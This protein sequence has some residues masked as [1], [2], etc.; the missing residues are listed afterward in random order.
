MSL[1]A[2]LNSLGCGIPVISDGLSDAAAT[3][4]F[5]MSSGNLSAYIDRMAYLNANLVSADGNSIVL[6]NSTNSG[7]SVRSSSLVM[8]AKSPLVGASHFHIGGSTNMD[9]YLNLPSSPLSFSSN[10]LSPSVIHAS[11]KEQPTSSLRGQSSQLGEKKSCPQL[12]M[13]GTATSQ[14]TSQAQRGSH[15][16]GKRKEPGIVQ[17]SK[18]PRLDRNQENI[19]HQNIIQ[20]LLLQKQDPR[21]MPIQDHARLL[22]ALMQQ[23]KLRNQQQQQRHILQKLQQ[24]QVRHHLQQQANRQISVVQPHD[25]GICSRRLMQYIY[26]LRHRPPVSW[27][28]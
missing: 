14:T 13:G 26:H 18:K 20:H 16:T 22:Q 27:L 6:N 10:N 23:H 2:Y 28:I 17:M 4:H 19:L 24:Q 5:D 7:L 1:E 8:D 21:A 3:S 15:H 9:S 12:P 11:S 25:G